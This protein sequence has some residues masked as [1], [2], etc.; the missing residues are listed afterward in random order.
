M[1]KFIVYVEDEHLATNIRNFA[2]DHAISVEAYLIWLMQDAVWSH[3]ENDSTFDQE[4][5][6]YYKNKRP[7]QSLTDAEEE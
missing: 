1:A 6:D 4:E 5:N 3:R 7:R 2:G